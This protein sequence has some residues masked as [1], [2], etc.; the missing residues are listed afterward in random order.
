MTRTVSA[1]AITALDAEHLVGLILVELDFASG[2]LRACNAAHAILW[3]G[4][5]W[6]GLGLVGAID[7]VV[8]GG[9]L[10]SRGLALQLSG[11]DPGHV[12]LSLAEQYQG[13]S[14]KL[15]FALLDTT[16][17]LVIADPVGPW[18][19]RMDT[20][21]VT[22]GETAT[23]TVTAETRLSDWN[24]R[25]ARRYNDADQQAEFAGDKGLQY[26][27]QL[28]DKVIIWGAVPPWIPPQ[29]P[30][31]PPVVF[32]SADRNG[33]GNV[34]GGPYDYAAPASTQRR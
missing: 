1:G 9:G 2:F 19:Y 14:C 16:S 28:V 6:L 30:R 32:V 21:G 8:D 13:R 12:A 22:L 11:V 18:I 4:Y 27:E 24:R 3:G 17:A 20:M 15:W 5:S 34:A 33:P 31:A 7:P 10:Q 25:R 23:L 29:M 26:V